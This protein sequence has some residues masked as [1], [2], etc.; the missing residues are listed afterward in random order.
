MIAPPATCLISR[1]S[2]PRPPA[3]FRQ[4]EHDEARNNPASAS[5][6]DIRGRHP[7]ARHLEGVLDDVEEA[8]N[9]LAAHGVDPIP[10]PVAELTGLNQKQAQ[11]LVLAM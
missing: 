6:C 8:A 11:S 4:S 9:K 5:R 7:I 10:P 2:K 3:A 1:Y